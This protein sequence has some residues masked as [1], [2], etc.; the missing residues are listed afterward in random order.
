MSEILQERE[1]LLL[2]KDSYHL[3]LKTEGLSFDSVRIEGREVPFESFSF[4]QEEVAHISLEDRCTKASLYYQ[5]NSVTVFDKIP[6]T[7]GDFLRASL[8]LSP[9]TFGAK[10]VGTFLSSKDTDFSL[11]AGN[12]EEIFE[13]NITAHRDFEGV[14]MDRITFT[15]HYVPYGR[16]T[17]HYLEEDLLI[18][19]HASLARSWK[20]VLKKISLVNMLKAVRYI[21][22]GGLSSLS[23]KV[24]D[25][26]ERSVDAY[27]K[28]FKEER[29]REIASF[30]KEEF[31]YQ[32]LISVLVP[33]Y[34][35]PEDTL[36]EMVE[37]LRDQYY[38]NWELCIADGSTEGNPATAILENY[39]KEDARIKVLRLDK[40]YGISGNTN[41]ALSLA[42][43]DYIGLLDHDDFLEPYTLWKIVRELQKKPYDCIYTD[44]DKFD[45][46][47]KVFMD[48]HYK[49]DFNYDLLLSCNYITHFFL[50]AKKIVDDVK[51]FDSHYDGSQDYDFILRCTE[52]AESVCHIP[53]VLYHWR[54][55]AGSTAM[56]P[57]NKLYCFEAGRSA[58]EDHLKRKGID[59]KTSMAPNSWGF[60]QSVYPK[61]KEGCTEI[62]L[63]RRD[64]RIEKENCEDIYLSL[65]EDLL[66]RL[67]ETVKKAEYD[68]ILIHEEGMR[69][70]EKAV[71]EMKNLLYREDV[72]IVFPKILHN[73]KILSAGVYFDED[74]CPQFP[75]RGMDKTWEGYVR[76]LMVNRDVEIGSTRCFMIDRTKLTNHSFKQD[77][78][79]DSSVT[80]YFLS[81]KESKKVFCGTAVFT[82]D[83]YRYEGRLSKLQKRF[84]KKIR[85]ENAGEKVYRK[86]DNI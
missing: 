16:F 76:H 22:R 46:E 28:I 77:Y 36:K 56:D 79:Y 58:V 59:A 69:A 84:E 35:T 60:Y 20:T 64:G 44:E 43:G 63:G 67:N 2:H 42:T 23:D 78:G 47:K 27:D 5:G 26:S 86:Y 31:S 25:Y 82:A 75:Y 66:N 68:H 41:K 51:G 85:Y 24:L 62:I 65:G 80:D 34:N 13:A 40:N 48:P 30:Q 74:D 81:V 29:E 70:D 11:M 38:Q 52:R 7:E 21:R 54:I 50:A 9:E 61:T 71:E 37:S 1:A 33:A 4:G 3:F 72:S 6:L 10:I 8:D 19:K 32:P 57:A 12:D 49:P 55:I 83:R 18:N 14:S 15:F 17:L 53:Q 39:A 45:D 73:G